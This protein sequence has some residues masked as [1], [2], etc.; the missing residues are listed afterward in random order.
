[1]RKLTL[2]FILSALFFSAS[3]PAK[4]RTSLCAECQE[5]Y[6]L[7]DEAV[8]KS[9]FDSLNTRFHQLAIEH[10]DKNAELQYYLL[11]L[12]HLCRGS[13]KGQVLEAME[14]LKDKALK[15]GELKYY[16]N[17]YTRAAMYMTDI[18]NDEKAVMSLI[19]KMLVDA[20]NYGS[21]Y[22]F[23]EGNRY[24]ALIYWQKGDYINSRKYAL[25]AY[26][27]YS[28]TKDPVIQEETV[29]IRSLLELSET[30]TADN[31][32][33]RLFLDEAR[34]VA[35]VAVDTFRCNYHE[36][37]YYARTGDIRQ[38]RELRD[39]V[40]SSGRYYKHYYPQGDLLYRAT[41]AAI[42]GDWEAFGR[43]TDNIS[44][45]TDLKYLCELAARYGNEEY[46]AK[47]ESRIISIL[48]TTM[49]SSHSSDVS[50]LAALMGNKELSYSL[51][52]AEK[53]LDRSNKLAILALSSFLVLLIIIMVLYIIEKRK[54]DAEKENLIKKLKKSKDEADKANRL[55]TNFV[56]NMS[57]EIR[58]PLNS[59]VGFAQL[60][61]LPDGTLTP[62]EKDEYAKVVS[63]SSDV[64]I[65]L[66][67]DILNLADIENGNYKIKISSFNP[68]SAI[69]YAVK[70]VEERVPAGIELHTKINVPGDLVVKSDSLRIQQILT[71]FLTNAIKNTEKGFINIGCTTEENPG[72][73]SFYVEDSGIGI[74]PEKV[75]TIFERYVKLDTF[76][77]GA[78]LGLSICRAL[79]EKLGGRVYLDPNWSPGARFVLDV[80]MDDKGK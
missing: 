48:F 49:A 3:L 28:Q 77:Q 12:R 67:D 27:I 11:Q 78:G 14:N 6:E 7:V 15:N 30:Y 63:N 59:L 22:G 68:A 26:R 47:L 9:A 75:D 4:D 58:T 45:L 74:P 41:D 29:I 13:S 60:L 5:M 38:Y 37:R 72:F 57:H 44:S 23:Y 18:E 21:E 52:A 16:F 42:D 39:K 24:M 51:N 55:K 2:L 66:I 31:D 34:K 64:L 1:M 53:K 71:N 32:S 65:G 70:L 25:E 40:K 17:A 8:G 80:P 69:G 50:E 61:S 36:S 33:A 73:V 35:A 79:A 43:N 10:G 54:E 46:V 76:K 20:Q 19:E 62:E 56:Q